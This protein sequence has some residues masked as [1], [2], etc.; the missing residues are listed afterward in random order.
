V[1]KPSFGSGQD[2]L[3]FPLTEEKRDPRIIS[4]ESGASGLATLLTLC[5]ESS[6]AAADARAHLDLSPG[7]KVLLLNTEGDTDPEGFGAVVR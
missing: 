3:G 6:I 1:S 2:R 5:N 4:G 7:T